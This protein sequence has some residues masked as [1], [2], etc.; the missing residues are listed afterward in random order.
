[1]ERSSVKK[2]H[3]Q[4]EGFSEELTVCC[5]IMTDQMWKGF[6]FSQRVL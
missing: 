4:M 3:P 5:R 6:K 2:A 1:M